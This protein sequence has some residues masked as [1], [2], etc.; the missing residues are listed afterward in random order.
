M[1]KIS[2]TGHAVNCGNFGKLITVCEGFGTK[3]NPSNESITLTALKTMQTDVSGSMSSVAE[4]E[5]AF[6]QALNA[7]ATLLRPIKKLCTRILSAFS[8]CG[9][10]ASTI[11][12]MRGINRLIQGARADRSVLK[13]AAASQTAGASAVPAGIKI[14]SVSHQSV[15]QIL[16]NFLRMLTLLKAE[17]LYKPNEADLKVTALEAYY[18][19]LKTKNDAANAAEAEYNNA[20]TARNRV[21]YEPYTG[22]VDITK[23][24]KKYAKSVFGASSPEFLRVVVLQ[25]RREAK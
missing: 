2:E 12:D 6:L 24:V 14:N 8:A 11:E 10:G 4:K 5:T 20:L 21:L 16:D 17:K 25:F 23:L 22:M 7:R 18:T 19:D 13:A 1:A 3:Y 15:N 9:A